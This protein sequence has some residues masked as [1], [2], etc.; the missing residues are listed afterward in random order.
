MRPPRILSTSAAVLVALLVPAGASAAIPDPCPDDG[1]TSGWCGDGGPATEARLANPTAVAA[2]SDGGFLVADDVN[3][4]VRRISGGGVIRRI[5]GIGLAGDSGDGGPATGARTGH[6]SCVTELA[7]GS[8]LVKTNRRDDN[9]ELLGSAVRRISRGGTITTVDGQDPC[10][11]AILPGGDRLVVDGNQVTRVSAGGTT[12]VA[13]RPGCSGSAGDGGPAVEAQLGRP[14]AVA[15]L[16]D[17]GFLVADAQFH[18]VRRVSPGGVIDTVAGHYKSRPTDPD[19]SPCPQAGPSSKP[20]DYFVLTRPLKGKAR[21]SFGVRFVTTYAGNCVI[22]ITR[23]SKPGGRRAFTSPRF[24]CG[25]GEHVRTI[26]PR[27]SRG[28]YVLAIRRLGRART[29]IAPLSVTR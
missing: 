18:L 4:T 7:D 12:V 14:L 16:P 13:G 23:G 27:L 9:G 19:A 11:P 6:P 5:A 3:N 20:P 25:E 1:L 24:R 26:R 21:R 29:D 10:R 2:T 15:A 8:V 22:T 28:T 17:G